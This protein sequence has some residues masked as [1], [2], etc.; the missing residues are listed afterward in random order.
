MLR[1]LKKILLEFVLTVFCIVLVVNLPWLILDNQTLGFHFYHYVSSINRTLEEIL[2]F[3]DLTYIKS[4][5]K[6]YPL[7]PE[8]FPSY[9][10]SILILGSAFLLALS[11]TV[12]MGYMYMVTGSTTKR[13]IKSILGVLES[14]PDVMTILIVQLLVIWIFKMTGFLPFRVLSINENRAY[15]LPILCLSILPI[16][17]LLKFFLLQ[18]EEEW[19]KGY[20][21]VAYGKGLSSHYIVWVHVMRNV[22]FHLLNH[23]KTIYLF[24]LS[25]LLILESMFNTQGIMNILKYNSGGNPAVSAICLILMY[26]PFFIL[27]QFLILFTNYYSGG[28]EGKSI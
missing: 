15:F 10:Y 11:V 25:N 16:V 2:K 6:P 28:I 21:E 5:G 8:L 17:Q 18:L 12:M 23:I 7:F 14:V 26:I 1:Y 27:F 3:S 24:M 19:Q 22:F 13:I 20:I 9:M 4:S